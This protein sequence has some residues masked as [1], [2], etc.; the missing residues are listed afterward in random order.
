MK[1]DKLVYYLYC[2]YCK[3]KSKNHNDLLALIELGTLWRLISALQQLSSCFNIS[4]MSDE[5]VKLDICHYISFLQEHKE[6]Q[7]GV[8]ANDGSKTII[9]D[10]I[11]QIIIND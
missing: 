11:N 5:Q 6:H 3:E 7:I 2:D 9:N 1:N 10:R 8:N 4:Y